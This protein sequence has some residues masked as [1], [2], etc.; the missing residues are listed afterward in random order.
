V[1]KT[2]TAYALLFLV[3]SSARAHD[4]W[5]EPSSFRPAVGESVALRLKVG[6]HFEGD[7]V[8]RRSGRIERFFA[9]SVSGERAV[10][11][12]EGGDPAGLVAIREAGTTIVAYS[13]R[14]NRI[15]LEAAKFE[16]YLREEGLQS[17]IALRAER[18]QSAAPGR[19][20]FSRSVK[21]L[22]HR[23]AGEALDQPLGLRLE[24][25]KRG[26]GFEVLFE[27]RPLNNAL[28]VA[29][30]RG[31][32]RKPLRARTDTT[33]RV[34]FPAFIRGEWLVKAVHMVPAPESADAEWESLWASVT[35]SAP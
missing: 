35:F 12:K 14:P 16:A 15:V 2:L 32:G 26:S 6:E 1:I 27:G 3:A 17:V 29:L 24:V 7:A 11:G 10:P 4:F 13:G 31:E 8:P 34:T 9:R 22:L 25:V 18:G 20:I 21:T 28:V 33:G 23:G 30:R 19:E 5:I